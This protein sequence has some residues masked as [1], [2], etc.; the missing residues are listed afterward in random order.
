MGKEVPVPGLKVPFT[1]K[2]SLD[3]IQKLRLYASSTGKNLSEVVAQAL[4]T[5]LHG[6]HG[7]G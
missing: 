1:V 4:E 2:L 3:L 6:I 5:F 7:R